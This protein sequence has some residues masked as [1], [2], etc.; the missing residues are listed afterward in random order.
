MVMCM[1]VCMYHAKKYWCFY[2]M[3]G[4]LLGDNRDSGGKAVI[5]DQV[6]SDQFGWI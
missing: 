2:S 1:C 5:S 6:T 4:R 3:G